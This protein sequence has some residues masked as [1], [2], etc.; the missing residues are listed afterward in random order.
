MKILT[1]V[2]AVY[3]SLAFVSYVAG[4]YQPDKIIVGLLILYV[5]LDFVLIALRTNG[6][7]K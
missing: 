1:A 2:I 6:E 7:A 4:T 3:W 5:A